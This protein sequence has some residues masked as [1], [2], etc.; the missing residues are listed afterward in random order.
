MLNK[1]LLII[2]VLLF[3]VLFFV[4]LTRIASAGSCTVSEAE[5]LLDSYERQMVGLINNFRT[6]K[7]LN[8][9]TISKSLNRAAQ[10]YA[11][12]ITEGNYRYTKPDVLVEHMDGSGRTVQQRTD[13]CGYTGRSGENID[14]IGS[15]N[16]DTQVN[17]AFTDWVNSPPHNANMSNTTIKSIGVAYAVRPDPTFGKRAYWVA[18]FGTVLDNSGENDPTITP[19]PTSSNPTLT[20][21]ISQNSPTPVPSLQPVYST[22]DDLND[23]GLINEIDLSILFRGFDARTGD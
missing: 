20:P 5:A 15:E 12:E 1:K 4:L 21:T 18:D 17:Q 11:N 22:R 10:M 23:D 2:P 14:F 7:G 6:S 16:A 9:L 3:S 8:T 19:A 13:D